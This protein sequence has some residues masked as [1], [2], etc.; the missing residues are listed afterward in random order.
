MR[1]ISGAQGLHA[2]NGYGPPCGDSGQEEKQAKKAVEAIASW[3]E[4][5]AN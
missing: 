3:T 2:M 5:L 1:H 4:A